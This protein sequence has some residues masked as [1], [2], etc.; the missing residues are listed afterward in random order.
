MI[1]AGVALMVVG[2]GLRVGAGGGCWPARG[3]DAETD[4]GPQ[5][6]KYLLF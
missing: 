2:R 4:H 5:A 3:R 1:T 6:A